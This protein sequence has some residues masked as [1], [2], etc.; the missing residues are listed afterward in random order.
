MEAPLP[1]HRPHWAPGRINVLELLAALA[2]HRADGRLHG[3]A[4]GPP[5]LD[6]PPLARGGPGVLQPDG[7]TTSWEPQEAVVFIGQ[8]PGG[9]PAA[10]T[11]CDTLNFFTSDASARAWANEH[12]QVHGRVVGQGQALEIARQTFGPLLAP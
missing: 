6:L 3:Q 10:A 5:L 1:R 12:P 7:A 11:C 9:G 2:G 8:R 4:L